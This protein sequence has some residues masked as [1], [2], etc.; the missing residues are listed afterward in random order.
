MFTIFLFAYAVDCCFG[1]ECWCF[2]SHGLCAVAQ[3]EV[4]VLLERLPGENTLPRGIIK[5]F[6]HIYDSASKGNYLH[7]LKE[8]K[9]YTSR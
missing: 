3:D 5:L 6:T 1:K 4:M 9:F 8:H 7:Y 2:T